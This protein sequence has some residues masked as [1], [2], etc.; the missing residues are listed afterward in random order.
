MTSMQGSE[1]LEYGVCGTCGYMMF[2]VLSLSPCGHPGRVARRAL[3][4]TGIVY[5]WTRIRLGQDRLLV[6]A[7]F[8]DGG[9]RVTGPLLDADQVEIGDRVRLVEGVDSP[10]AFMV[11]G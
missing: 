1:S 11:A 5:S 9:L 4:E 10:Y 6:M 3:D 7:D 2:P 8:F